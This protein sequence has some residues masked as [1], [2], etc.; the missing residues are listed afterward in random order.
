MRSANRESETP[1]GL[2]AH[3]LVEARLRADAA[4]ARRTAP[5]EL[6]A[7]IR[8]S[9]RSAPS[10]RPRPL[11]R[12]AWLPIAAALLVLVALQLTRSA[13]VA[14][15]SSETT[16]AGLDGTTQLVHDLLSA[17]FTPDQLLCQLTDETLYGEIRG[18]SSEGARAARI[19]SHL[20]PRPMREALL[21]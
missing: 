12:W 8:W 18:I 13:G 11:L 4:G 21:D 15:R 6:G 10:A 19:Y 16:T 3:E 7:R 9:L 17:S 2:G 14:E 5:A 1:Q 20:V